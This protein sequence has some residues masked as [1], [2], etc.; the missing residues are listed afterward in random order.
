VKD[1]FFAKL[2]QNGNKKKSCR[3]K[4]SKDEV[5][6]K[7]FKLKINEKIYMRSCGV[8]MSLCGWIFTTIKGHWMSG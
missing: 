3:M 6:R 5:D 4:E 8:F 1:F 7:T 2:E